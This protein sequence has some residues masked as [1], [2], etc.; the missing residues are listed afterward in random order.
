[1]RKFAL[2]AALC[3][4]SIVFA[5]TQIG[6]ASGA[7][8]GIQIGGNVPG[9]SSIQG[10]T[11]DFTFSGDGFG[12]CSTTGGTTTCT[13][14]GGSGAVTS[15]TTNYT[16]GL[17]SLSGGVL[18]I[19][20][21][22]GGNVWLAPNFDSLLGAFTDSSGNAI[23][24]VSFGN[25]PTTFH[26]PPG[27]TQLQ[28]GC[29][30][31]GDGSG[32]WVIDVNGTH[33]TVPETAQPW[34]NTGG[35]NSRFPVSPSGTA[36][37]PVVVPIGVEG[38]AVT[39]TYVSGL[40]HDTNL[41]GVSGSG[42][43][44]ASGQPNCTQSTFL[45]GYL[46]G[47]WVMSAPPLTGAGG[48]TS[49]NGSPGAFTFSGSGVSCSGTGCTFSGG[50][51]PG[52]TNG[53][54][55]YNNSGAFGGDTGSTTDGAGNVTTKTVSTTGTVA[56][57]GGTWNATEGTAPSA[58]AGHDILYAD[59][60]AHCI[61]LSNNA[62][63]FNC[64]GTG[65]TVTSVATGTGLTG[66]PITTTGTISCSD[67][68]S[69]AKG[70][71]QVDGT[72]I[73]ATGG[74]ISAIG[75][76]SGITSLTGDVTATGPGAAAATIANNAV[77]TAKI[78]NSA[79]T[80]AKIQNAAANSKLI[81]SGSA[82]SGS[83][84][85]EITLGAN[86]SMS[87]TTLSATSSGGALNGTVIYT[88]SQTASTSDNGKLVVFNCSTTC[89]Y[90]LPASQPSTTWQAWVMSI[91]A[92]T[93]TILL[94]GG[95]TFNGGATAPTINNFRVLD[96]W[97]DSATATNYYGQAPYGAGSG[98]VITPAASGTTIALATALPNGT[99]ATTQSANDN[100][101][102]VATTAYVDTK[103]RAWS[104]QPGLGDGL[105]AVTAGTYLESTCMNT[106]GVTVTLTG[107]SCFTD[108]SGSSTMNASGNTLGALLTGAVTCSTAFAAGT[109]SANVALTNGDYIK[110]TFV[111][112]GT[113][114]QTTWVVKGTY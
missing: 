41:C 6:P 81:G 106:T 111:A 98:I 24:V 96:L 61:K 36:T 42:N 101:T 49:I 103:S 71:V 87:G 18:N 69:G 91:G 22:F 105:N 50:T 90:T 11:G 54:L 107:L 68:T 104:C 92:T 88:S 56:G 8:A 46:P 9:V 79:V 99:T 62:G 72:S 27:A 64:I 10:Q 59:S 4:P 95:D 21:N 66:G 80:L 25:G 89:N 47:Y 20:I 14:S 83:P 3:L 108:N 35:I 63:S 17:A 2:F 28:L 114:K 44:D 102:K 19:P 15:L 110:F 100:S 16:S 93:A 52:G 40:I 112:D 94:G 78:N 74:V 85:A 26:V 12:G 60:T 38:T 86:L 113:S 13:F 48:V 23:Q 65:G 70:C 82:G 73:T 77:T 39:V 33:Y 84:Y 55:Q 97:A 76:G 32:S 57:Q 58:A 37:A 51:S 30:D 31:N 43:R 29:N 67:A 75:S 1:M 45:G 5:Q 53:Q 109:Q 34:V 7:G